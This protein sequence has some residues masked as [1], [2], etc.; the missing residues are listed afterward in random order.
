M[1]G[2]HRKPPEY[3]HLTI[4]T[5]VSN[6][7]PTYLP[8]ILRQRRGKCQFPLIPRKPEF[9]RMQR[10][11]RLPEHAL[12]LLRPAFRNEF[13]VEIR[14]RPVNLVAD[15]RMSEMRQV[16]SDLVQASRMRLQPQQ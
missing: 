3:P 15:H 13:Q 8:H 4:T 5:K 10:M 9:M 7:L 11:P 1:R 14:V 16:H 6:Q 2:A 12:M